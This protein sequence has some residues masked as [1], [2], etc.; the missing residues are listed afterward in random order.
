MAKD[1]LNDLSETEQ[2]TARPA[3]EYDIEAI[4]EKYS[5]ESFRAE[6]KA[7]GIRNT[8]ELDSAEVINLISRLA[9][10][11]TR[12]ERVDNPEALA[13]SIRLKNDAFRK[14]V[15]MGPQPDG[16]AFMTSTIG[17][18]AEQTKAMLFFKIITFDGFT[19]DN[20]PYGEH[21]FGCV[22]L[23]GIPKVYWSINYYE[24]AS[25]TEIAEDPLNAYRVLIVM[26]A[27]EY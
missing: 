4:R 8:E 19:Q 2:Q 7:R 1:Y 18:L 12:Y 24:D 27:K 11:E 3:K 16:K 6:L 9:G 23:D 14:A 20:D 22:E 21:D 17:N 26:F 10:Y 15:F 25:L 13:K 5:I